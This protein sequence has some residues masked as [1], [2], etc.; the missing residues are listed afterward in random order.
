MGT[1]LRLLEQE[2]RGETAAGS[3]AEESITATPAWCRAALS[4][5][6]LAPVRRKI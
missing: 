5:F 3:P 6:P 1:A 4:H 2:G